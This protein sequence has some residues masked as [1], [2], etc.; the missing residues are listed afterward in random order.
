MTKIS[1][2]RYNEFV[3]NNTDDATQEITLKTAVCHDAN[4]FMPTFS[5]LMSVKVVIMITSRAADD[6]KFGIM[7]ILGFLLHIALIQVLVSS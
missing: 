6:S 1:P 4:F 5:S 7:T 3:R 2:Q